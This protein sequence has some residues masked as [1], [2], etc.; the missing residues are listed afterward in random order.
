MKKLVLFL[1][2]AAFTLTAC[3]GEQVE[4]VPEPHDPQPQESG[5]TTQVAAAPAPS[6]TEDDDNDY[7]IQDDEPPVISDFAFKMGDVVIEMNQNINYV[8]DR[9]GEPLGIIEEPSCA[10]DGIDRIFGYPG[11]QFYTYP[12][13]DDDFIH[14]IGFFDDSVKTMEGGIRLGSPLQDVLDAYGEDYEHD[15]GMYT[16]RR[17][18]TSLQFMIEDGFVDFI[19]YGFIIEQE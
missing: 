7:T 3:G 9:L 19:S 16:F 4:D 12:I 14:T 1:I 10:F 17:G 6:E 13:G 8:I 18:L 5:D 2:L 15:T 11:V